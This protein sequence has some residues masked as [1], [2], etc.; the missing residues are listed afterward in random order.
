MSTNYVIFLVVTVGL[1]SFYVGFGFAALLS[2]GRDR[3][4]E[5]NRGDKHEQN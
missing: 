2:A 4:D 3:R 1:I 5:E